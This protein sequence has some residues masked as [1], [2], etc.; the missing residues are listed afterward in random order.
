MS[1]HVG[2]REGGREGR[3]GFVLGTVL[4]FIQYYFFKCRLHHLIELESHVLLC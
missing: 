3:L 4:S 1:F 2:G